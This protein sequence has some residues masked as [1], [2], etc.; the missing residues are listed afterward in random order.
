M[1]RLLAAILMLI[2]A[3]PLW[4]D[5]R[6]TVLMDVLQVRNLSQILQDEGIAFGSTL[7]E[8]WL[9]GKGGA[10]WAG[11][12][13]RIYDAERISE[14]IR[15]GLEPALEGQT[16]ED[17]IAFFASDLGTKVITLENSA[18][19]ALA[20]EGV[21]EEARSRFAAL[22][23]SGGSRLTQI[24]RMIDAGDLINRNV[25]SALNSNYQFLRALVDGDVYAMS[26]RD[27]LE[28]VFSERD[29]IA[30]DTLGW[31]GAFMLMAYSPLTLEELTLYADFVE[32]EAGKTLNAGLFAGFDPLYEDISYA[33]GRAMAL[34]MAAE[35]L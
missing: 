29:A 28:D 21:E 27:I 13:T 26:D 9:D 7:N 4:A 20:I 11:Q 30:T 19:A 5:A 8:E 14:V 35:E 23:K 1:H 17:V 6:H 18:R 34:N 3:L 24:S 16:L 22:Q 15:E 32:T 12:V 10:A 33:L 2:T 31:L 25:T